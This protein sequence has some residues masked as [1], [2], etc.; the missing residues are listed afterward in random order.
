MRPS[1]LR[2]VAADRQDLAGILGY[3][4]DQVAKA[5]VQNKNAKASLITDEEAGSIRR[6]PG[7][8]EEP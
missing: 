7:F 6:D 4:A 1:Q 8:R 3:I 2:T 5:K